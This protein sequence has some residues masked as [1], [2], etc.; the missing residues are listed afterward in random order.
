MELK[1]FVSKALKE[2][3]DGVQEARGTPDGDGICPDYDSFKAEGDMLY[4]ASNNRIAFPIRFDVAITVSESSSKE[5][6]ASLKVWSVGAGG[7]AGAENSSVSVSRISFMVPIAFP[8]ITDK[9]KLV[10]RTNKTLSSGP[11]GWV[12]N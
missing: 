4:S 12:G 5:G 9:Q 11:N 7:K 8:R 1:E 2:I 6:G 10:A 3:L